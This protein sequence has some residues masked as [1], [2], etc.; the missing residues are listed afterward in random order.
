MDR[1]KT[2]HSV[3][4]KRAM[5]QMAFSLSFQMIKTKIMTP[6]K[7]PGNFLEIESNQRSVASFV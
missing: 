7:A 2:Y 1:L 6:F 4:I 5:L 3:Q